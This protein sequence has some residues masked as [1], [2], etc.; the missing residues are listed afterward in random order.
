MAGH[1]WGAAVLC[2]CDCGGGNPLAVPQPF[3][4]GV[5]P[6][7]PV[8]LRVLLLRPG[9]RGAGRLRGVLAFVLLA[10]AEHLGLPLCQ[11]LRQ[12]HGA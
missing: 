4:R 12:F 6:Q 10:A 7:I 2:G 1:L 9:G 5:S 8:A 3:P 11:R